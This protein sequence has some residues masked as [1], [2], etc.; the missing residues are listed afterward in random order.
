M[1]WGLAQ[2]GRSEA[3]ARNSNSILTRRILEKAPDLVQSNRRRVPGES[4]GQSQAHRNSGDSDTDA[5]LAQWRQLTRERPSQEEEMY[6]A[7]RQRRARK[8]AKPAKKTTAF[9]PDRLLHPW[10]RDLN[11][12]KN[13]IKNGE[14]PNAPDRRDPESQPDDDHLYGD[15][16]DDGYEYDPS[17]P[18]NAANYYGSGGAGLQYMYEQ[19]YPDEADDVED[20]GTFGAIPSRSV[21]SAELAHRVDTELQ[22]SAAQRTHAHSAGYNSKKKPA[23]ITT[24]TGKVLGA[25]NLPQGG[26]LPSLGEKATAPMKL[27]GSQSMPALVPRTGLEK[28]KSIDSAWSA[29][30]G[31]GNGDDIQERPTTSDHSNS[32]SAGRGHTTSANDASGAFGSPLVDKTKNAG[33]VNA[34]NRVNNALIG[35]MNQGFGTSMSSSF[36]LG[37]S[38]SIPEHGEGLDD[39]DYESPRRSNVTHHSSVSPLRK[40]GVPP[41]GRSAQKKPKEESSDEGEEDDGDDED[42]EIGWSPFTITA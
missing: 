1:P 41:S 8:V 20:A 10:Q 37:T 33:V 28:L 34:V 6:E 11:A 23:S 26:V 29:S 9:N 16:I 24:K 7:E 38:E 40:V 35:G 5:V 3:Y 18:T 25:K 4:L 19:D 2:E 15:S 12:M 39:E 27:H 31:S 21:H 42:E 17:D 13:K 22:N 14:D 30:R 32:S 36:R